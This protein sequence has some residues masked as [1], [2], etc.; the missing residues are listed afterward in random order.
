MI[1]TP[2]D[3]AKHIPTS[4]FALVSRGHHYHYAMVLIGNYQVTRSLRRL[5]RMKDKT[6]T[7]LSE[8]H[9]FVSLQIFDYK[10]RMLVPITCGFCFHLTCS[11]A[12]YDQDFSNLAHGYMPI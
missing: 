4:N 3:G 7:F 10:V 2:L 8:R 1:C 9:T 11:R 6:K 5:N 12:I